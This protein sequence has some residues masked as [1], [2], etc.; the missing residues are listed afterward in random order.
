MQK[1]F[2]KQSLTFCQ[3]ALFIEKLGNECSINFAW[4]NITL[5]INRMSTKQQEKT[6]ANVLQN[7]PILPLD[8]EE[9]SITQNLV[10]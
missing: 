5:F 8:K 1:T 3:L 7:S 6:I 4:P 2:Q 9:K 10:L